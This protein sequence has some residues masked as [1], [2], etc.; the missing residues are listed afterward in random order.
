MSKQRV[1]LFIK[2]SYCFNKPETSIIRTN[3]KT[4][5]LR[6]L[7]NDYLRNQ[8]GKGKDDR[9]PNEKEVYDI[10]I[11]VDLSDDTFYVASDTG[12]NSLTCGI[13]MHI[14]AILNELKVLPL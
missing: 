8:I 6:D 13:I 7:L 1:D 3:V 4:E 14:S 9:K 11:G 12:N 5:R 10:E 2:I